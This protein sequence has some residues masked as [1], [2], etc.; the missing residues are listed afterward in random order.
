VYAS[1]RPEDILISLMPIE[2]SARNSFQGKIKDIADT[3]TIVRI[4]VDAGIPFIA[5]VTRRSFHDMGLKLGIDVYLT[6]KA[7]DV[8]V[9]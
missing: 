7:T 4:T 9:F 3:G 5:A 2:S 6:F 1:V 8:H